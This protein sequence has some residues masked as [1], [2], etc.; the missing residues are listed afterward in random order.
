MNAY[1]MWSLLSK[2][3][4]L[5]LSNDWLAFR[6]SNPLCLSFIGGLAARFLLPPEIKQFP[7]C[8]CLSSLDRACHH[9]ALAR[10]YFRSIFYTG[11]CT[12]R[13]ELYGSYS[14]LFL[15]YSF[16]VN[17]RHWLLSRNWLTLFPSTLGRHF[18][19]EFAVSAFLLMMDTRTVQ[20]WGQLSVVNYPAIFP[21][22]S[23][24]T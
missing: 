13:W 8:Y 23:S 6:R 22:H 14:R 12:G 1:R 17:H 3:T 4:S 16:D 21:V 9:S 20:V 15:M 2:N 5:H 10:C 24:R 11:R 18:F 19:I 7:Q